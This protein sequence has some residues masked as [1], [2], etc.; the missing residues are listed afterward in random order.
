ML[1][2]LWEVAALSRRPARSAITGWPF[3]E[4]CSKPGPVVDCVPSSEDIPWSANAHSR[5]VVGSGRVSNEDPEPSDDAGVCRRLRSDLPRG[6]KPRGDL[7]SLAVGARQSR[8]ILG[9]RSLRPKG[10]PRRD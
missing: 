1:V 9:T 8:Q 3:L 4:T 6:A 10:R 7:L 5:L 2:A